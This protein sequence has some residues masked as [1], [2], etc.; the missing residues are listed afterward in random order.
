VHPTTDDR[1]RDLLRRR[2]DWPALIQTATEQRVLPLVYTS[3][4][5][6]GDD[7]VPAGH[8]ARLKELYRANAR[9]SLR[10]AQALLALLDL[11][12][13]R[14][15]DAIPLKGP[16]LA[17]QAYGDVA[18]SPQATVPSSPSAPRRS[19]GCAARSNT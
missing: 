19:P 10:S 12:A 6:L 13:D 7:L 9:A 4:Q 14:G 2:L 16:V 11:L 5:T 17:V 3:L 18:S 8:K 1:L 15:I